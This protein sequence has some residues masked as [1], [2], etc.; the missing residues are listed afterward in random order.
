MLK[1]GGPL[2]IRSRSLF[3]APL[4][5]METQFR[6]MGHAEDAADLALRLLSSLQGVMLLTQSFGDASLLEREGAR[7]TAWL[8][9]L[10]GTG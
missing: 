1:E 9:S 6:A 10:A 7:L 3:E 5:W 2:A 4:A 8:K